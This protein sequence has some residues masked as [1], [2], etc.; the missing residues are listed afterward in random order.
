MKKNI[1]L[2][3]V[4][5]L[6]FSS[7]IP[8]M[9]WGGQKKEKVKIV[10]WNLFDNS[11]V[12]KGQ[13]QAFRSTNSNVV[14]EYKKFNDPAF[15][16]ET[17]INELAEWNWPD[18]FTLKN[19]SIKKHKLKIEPL[20]IWH[21]NI[22][23][24]EQIYRETFLPVVSD[25]MIFDSKI[26]WVSLYTDSLA[27]Y[28]NK[29]F[30]KDNFTKWKPETT[31]AKLTKQVEKLTRKNN[32]I[33]RFWLSWIAMWRSDNI[34]RAVDILYLLMLQY[35]TQFFDEENKRIIF[36]DTQWKI[37][38][39]WESNL[40]AKTALNLYTSFWKSSYKNYSWNQL[41]T[42]RYSEKNEMYPFITGKTAMIFWYSYLYEDMV[43]SISQF[44]SSWKDTISKADIWIA[45]I[46]QIQNYSETWKRDS[47][48]SYYPLVVSKN[49]KHPKEAWDLLLY[50]SSKESLTD[51]H[52]KTN[53]P[54]SRIDLIEDQKLEK[55]FW[56]FAR[57][58]TYSKSYPPN[59]LDD[60]K[61]EIIFKKIIDV[62]VKSIKKPQKALSE[63]Q[64]IIDCLSNKQIKKEKMLWVNCMNE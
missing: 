46:P 5:I 1:A 54:S 13:L 40:P 3:L 31:W 51:Y 37:K 24:S 12:F 14:V 27:L 48:A 33:E 49:S 30:F 29:K 25:D 34:V 62:V 58:A 7:C 56:V 52:E 9:W 38:W 15:Y 60:K 64:W 11:D 55:I 16:E 45:E 47:L 36:A 22:A 41:I 39:T 2:F 50:L 17:L 18:I 21:T 63:W 32:S 42:S 59:V 20:K 10:I 44:R 6:L 43:S 8:W 57:Q 53:K 35:W 23:M 28:F 19:T 26:Y 61:Y 4:S